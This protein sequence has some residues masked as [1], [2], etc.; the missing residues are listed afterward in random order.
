MSDTTKKADAPKAEP[1][2]KEALA[3]GKAETVT[4]PAARTD[5]GKEEKHK[6]TPT[7]SASLAEAFGQPT[8]VEK[9]PEYKTLDFGDAGSLKV[10]SVGQ[11]HYGVSGSEQDVTVRVS[12]DET[13]T[14]P[15][16]KTRFLKE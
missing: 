10:E 13:A 8:P 11:Q 5:S 1:A 2:N 12:D 6:T 9:L 7:G 16:V 15:N 14:I 4:V 3:A